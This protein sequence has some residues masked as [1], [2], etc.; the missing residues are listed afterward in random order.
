MATGYSF[1]SFGLGAKSEPTSA[2]APESNADIDMPILINE[3]GVEVSQDPSP[4]DE[5]AAHDDASGEQQAKEAEEASG[6]I[7]PV[8]AVAPVKKDKKV[9]FNVNP[10]RTLKEKKVEQTTQP[11]RQVVRQQAPAPI[12]AA[13]VQK[14]HLTPKP[15]QVSTRVGTAPASAA[16]VPLW[17]RKK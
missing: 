15:A 4:I 10:P 5:T 12:P 7:V 14:R 11:N 3:S 6:D 16:P 17:A 13:P 9:R 8:N 2:A 1:L